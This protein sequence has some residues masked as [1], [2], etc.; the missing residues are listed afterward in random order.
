MTPTR[1]RSEV[2]RQQILDAAS[3]LFVS[4]SFDAVSMD[5]VAQLAGV[6]KQTVYSHFGNKE[7]LFE[8][9]I[10]GRCNVYQINEA[11][12]TGHEANT[13]LQQFAQLFSLLILSQEALAVFR[14]CIAQS[15]THP[16][17][18]E[19]YF[20][21]GPEQVISLFTQYLARLTEQGK[22]DIEQPRFAA[23]QFLKMVQGEQRMRKELNLPEHLAD[24]EHQRYV[25][26]CVDMFI[27]A[28]Q[29][30]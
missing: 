22:A 29:V 21:A 10:G 18:A 1:S 16:Q 17:L 9:A 7:A 8:A 20:E 14:T 15:L 4:H 11:L 27:R 26:S 24:E 3:E 25:K 2:K 19:I 13:V 28:Y 12:F 23:V 30:R 6:S 5:R